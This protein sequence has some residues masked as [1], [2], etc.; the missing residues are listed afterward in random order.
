[1]DGAQGSLDAL[2]KIVDGELLIPCPRLAVF[3]TDHILAVGDKTYIMFDSGIR[4]ASD[5]VKALCLGAQ[6][7]KS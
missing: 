1:V 3:H 4:G 6:F 7:G 5:V 2:E